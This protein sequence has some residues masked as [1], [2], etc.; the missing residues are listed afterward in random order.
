MILLRPLASA[1]LSRCRTGKA[2][3]LHL[4]QRGLTTLQWALGVSL[5]VHGG[6]LALRFGPP[7]LGER[8]LRDTPLEVILVNAR[9]PD[10][11]SQAQALAQANL[12]GGGEAQAGRA[13]SPLPASARERAG[14]DVLD[15]QER[16]LEALKAQQALLLAQ[17]KQQLAQYSPPLDNAQAP[18]SPAEQE[19]E[20]KRQQLVK[21]LAEVERRIQEENAR[22]R[23]QFISPA[24]REAVYAL[25]YDQ[26]RRRI[27][28]HGTANF[29]Q[30]GGKKLYGELT[31]AI[32]VD[33]NGH[34]LQTDILESSGQRVLDQRAQAIVRALSFGPFSEAMLR[35]A[36]Q[37]VVVSRFRFTREDTLSTT[38]SA[39]P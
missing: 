28:A 32:T 14:D 12:A 20:R 19:R 16:R 3:A 1:S 13:T 31:M 4:R 18:Q 11:P 30:A 23:K 8:I 38:L 2:G 33:R 6:L 36:D 5:A 9:S 7:E 27:E 22:P 39:Q 26:L 29:P 17:I 25:Y 34:V 35:R 15:A 24:T 10:A 37:I 21:L